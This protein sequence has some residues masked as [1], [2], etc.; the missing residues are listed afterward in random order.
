M[1]LPTLIEIV[2]Q[3]AGIIL[4]HTIPLRTTSTDWARSILLRLSCSIS[5]ALLPIPTT[6]IHV[7]S[8]STNTWETS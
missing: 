5:V 3:I 2:K 6:P 7:P 4:G 8:P 1:H